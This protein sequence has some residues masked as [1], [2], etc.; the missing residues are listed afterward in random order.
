[1]KSYRPT[2]EAKPSTISMIEGVI[3]SALFTHW[4]KLHFALNPGWYWIIGVAIW[5]LFVEAFKISIVTRLAATVVV[6]PFIAFFGFGLGYSMVGYPVG[7]VFGIFACLL[8]ISFH[9][10][11]FEKTRKEVPKQAWPFFAILLVVSFCIVFGWSR[12]AKLTPTP[13]PEASFVPG[14]MSDASVQ[15]QPTPPLPNEL[16]GVQ[17][18]SEFIS[19]GDVALMQKAVLESDDKIRVY[20]QRARMDQLRQAAIDSI[21]DQVLEAHDSTISSAWARVVE[22][23]PVKES[24]DLNDD[25]MRP[26]LAP[27]RDIVSGKVTLE[28]RDAFNQAATRFKELSDEASRQHDLQM[29]F[30]E[31]IRTNSKLNQALSLSGTGDRRKIWG[32]H[33]STDPTDDRTD[34]PNLP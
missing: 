4:I 17:A 24:Y 22:A 1:M 16:P 33:L 32:N 29:Q 14:P 5:I 31:L 25:S 10:A 9:F 26:F 8:S 34:D 23:N 18:N 2:D 30:A 6:T 15:T 28:E 7:I 3:V 12:S 27:T 21:R 20:D 11:D 19:P 13:T